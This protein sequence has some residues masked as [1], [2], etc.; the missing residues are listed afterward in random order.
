[1]FLA[2]VLD[3]EPGFLGIWI[4]FLALGVLG[5]FLARIRW[6]AGLA[7][8]PAVAFFSFRLFLELYD[9]HVG[10]TIRQEGGL[11]YVL[12]V[13]AAVLVGGLPPLVASLLRL[14]RRVA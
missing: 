4:P 7:V 1:M 8:L 14:R 5:V 12:Q 3:K 9:P 11:S 2:E 13:Y 10:P 6:W